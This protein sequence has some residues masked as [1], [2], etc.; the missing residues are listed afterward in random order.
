MCKTNYFIYLLLSMFFV[1]NLHS[2]VNLDFLKSGTKAPKTSNKSKE[3]AKD[4]PLTHPKPYNYDTT[5]IYEGINSTSYYV[6]MRDG[7]KLAV[8]VY[9]PQNLPEGTKLPVL[10]RQTRYWR[11]P[12][13]HLPLSFLTNGLVGRI[14]KMINAFVE[15]GYAIV[16]V[17]VRG[18]GASFG[19]RLH[20][21]SEDEIQDGYDIIEWVLQQEWSDGEIG[22]LGVS[23]G[24]TSAE[25]LGTT[26][27][28]NLKAIAPMYSLFDVYEDNA[29]PGGVHHHWFTKSWSEANQRMDANKLPPNYKKMFWLINGASKVKVE[30]SGK[31]M[32]QAIR[33]HKN[34]RTV[35]ES[36]LTIDFRDDTPAT[37]FIKSVD[38]F[39]PHAYL[40]Q[41]D[42]S[43]IAVYSYSGWMDGAYQNSAI[44]RHLNLTNPDNKLIIGPWEHGGKYNV[45]PYY[46]SLAGFDHAGELIKFFDYHLKNKYNDLDKEPSIH[47]YTFGAEK[48]QTAEEWPPKGATELT[49][50]LTPDNQLS[51]K[52]STLTETKLTHEVDNTTGTGDLSRWKS[53]NG[54]VNTAY[55]YHDWDARSE[56]LLSFTSEVLS[57]D[58]EVTGHPIFDLFMSFDKNDGSVFVYLEDID[59]VGTAHYV[60]EG[61]LRA[62]HRAIQETSLYKEVGP[63]ISHK[64]KHAL[65]VKVG[66]VIELKA[67]M[68]PTSY[69]FQ[70]GHRIR[71]SLAGADIDHFEILHPD[72]YNFELHTGSDFPS[73]VMLPV[74]E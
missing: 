23:Y 61:I 13:I 14:G 51:A 33:E 46:P 21:W 35:H 26:E 39:S 62:T 37:N 2:Q 30:D 48:W 22:S 56:K 43:G 29:F 73:K 47:Y 71:I 1:L 49:F 42:K 44:K 36:A 54:K 19:Q 58:V 18:S 24:G 68:I 52:P 9:L 31:L 34:N 40:Q 20:P 7:K 63:A 67:D 4:I 28:P 8:D 27:H 66:E 70:E 57:K 10:I 6:E 16:N 5:R 12:Q 38:L 72:G 3:T 32:N 74:Y 50:Y 59:E 60:T 25:F 65:P 17:D 15:N 53:L 64:R 41:L 55:M 11:S 45:S 69:L